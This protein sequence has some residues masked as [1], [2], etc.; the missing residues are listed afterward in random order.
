MLPFVPREAVSSFPKSQDPGR[1]IG[2]QG[3]YGT[4]DSGTRCCP[5]PG[6]RVGG[7]PAAL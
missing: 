5:H 7:T 6:D 2:S 3:T 4:P 1:V